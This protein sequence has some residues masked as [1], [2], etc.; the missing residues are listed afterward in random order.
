MEIIFHWIGGATFVMTIGN[1][2]IACDPVLCE[3]GEIQDFFGSNPN[4]LKSRCMTK[5]HLAT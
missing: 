2:N 4:D 5:K 1:L 3:K